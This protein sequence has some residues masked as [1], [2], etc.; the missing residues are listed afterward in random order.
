MIELLLVVTLLGVFISSCRDGDLGNPFQIYF[1]IWFFIFFL[2]WAQIET[3]IPISPNFLVFI[4]FESLVS[5]LLLLVFRLQP[6]AAEVVRPQVF[7]DDFQQRMIFFAQTVIVVA[8]PF[9]FFRA[10]ELSGGEGVFSISG[11]TN[12]RYAVTEGESNYGFLTYIFVLSNVVCSLSLI[13]FLRS[14]MSIWRL[15]LLIIVGLFYLYLNTARTSVLIFLILM[16]IPLVIM[17]VIGLRGVVASVVF[18]LMAFVFVAGMT[19]KG[20]SADANLFDNI[21]SF[22]DNSRSYTVAPI[23]AFSDF[24]ESDPPVEWGSNT[25]RFFIVLINA[26]GLSDVEPVRLIRDYSFVPDPTN[27]YTVYEVYFRDFSYVGLLIP[28]LFLAIH[29]ILYRRAIV[30]GGV[31]VFL[32][33]ISVYPLVMQFF[34]DQYFSLFSMWIQ[35][36][37]W[38][39]LFLSAKVKLFLKSGLHYD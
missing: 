19:A 36:V 21:K 3:F 24:I 5:L 16:V 1:S 30:F 7:V 38:F 12:L 34:Q 9:V 32:Y 27:V 37:F 25:F 29:W 11:Y 2:Y 28:I 4:F 22:L 14:S 23:L 6:R 26:F 31:W 17:G 20:V 13:L 8:L 10:N 35:M 15:L 33:S 18:L 39:W